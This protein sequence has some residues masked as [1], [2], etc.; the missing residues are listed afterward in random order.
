MGIFTFPVLGYPRN[1]GSDIDQRVMSLDN[2]CAHQCVCVMVLMQAWRRGHSTNKDLRYV[3]RE[4]WNL[5]CSFQAKSFQ[6]VHGFH[7]SLWLDTD[8]YSMGVHSL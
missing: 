3:Q 8:S 6:Y 7:I 1:I 5:F 2:L 4:E